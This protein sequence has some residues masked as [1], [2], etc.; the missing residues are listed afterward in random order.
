MEES[1]RITLETLRQSLQAVEPAALLV[2]PRIL[3]RVIRHDRRLPGLGVLVPHRKSYTIERERLL[4]FVDRSE[5][6]LPPSADLPRTVILLSKPAEDEELVLGDGPELLHQ[7]WRQLFHA[8]VHVELEQH[9][10]H[11]ES[12]TLLAMQRRE[13]IGDA[14]FA[15]IRAVLLKDDFLFPEPSDLEVY[16]EFAAVYLELRYFAEQELPLYF[17]AIRDWGEIDRIVSQDIDHAPLFVGARLPG[18]P[19]P[20]WRAGEQFHGSMEGAPAPLTEPTRAS[21]S[22]FRVFQAR[23][24]RA[25]A[26]GNGIKA[27]IWQMR[28]ARVGTK[29]GAKEARAA[30]HLELNRFTE[31][32]RLA[33]ES[34]PEEAQEWRAALEPLLTPAAQGYWSNEARLLYDLQKVCVERERGVFKLDLIEWLRTLGRRPMRRPLPLLREALT[35]RHL[36]TAQRRVDASR[37]TVGDRERLS[38]LLTAAVSSAEHRVRERIRPLV[39]EVFDDVGLTPQNTP[40]RVARRKLIEELL[41]RIVDHGYLSMG[42]LRDALSKNDLKLP[43]VASPME[44]VVGDRLLQ[45]DRKLDTVLD[46][47]YRRGAVYLR[48]PQT[49]SSLAFGTN[50]GRFITQYVAVPFGGAYLTLEFLS[51]VVE[52]ISGHGHAHGHGPV[53]TSAG[54]DEITE[55][56]AEIAAGH[57][58][59]WLY[60]TCVLALGVW[61]LL[62]IHNPGF[63]AW[64]VAALLRGW[65]LL[66]DLLVDLPARLIRS[67]L[68]QRIINSQVYAAVHSYVLRPAFTTFLVWLP[69]LALGRPWSARLALEIFLVA[70]LFLNSPI[71]RYAVELATDLLVRAWHELRMRIFAAVFQWIMDLSHAVM[72]AL[73]RVVYTVDEWLRFRTGDSRVA[74]AFKLLGGVV[75]FFVAYVVVFAFTLLIEPQVNPIKHFPVVTVSHKLILPSGPMF[76]REL[77]PYIGRAE[78]NT[79]VWTTIWLIPGVFGFLVWELKENWRLYAANRPRTLRGVSIGHH[80]ETMARLLRP[81]FHSGT[82]PKAFATLRR[83]A[84]KAEK[85]GDWKAISRKRSVVKHVEE[86]VCRFVE[87]ELVEL[88]DEVGFMAPGRLSVGEVRTATNRI[89]VELKRSDQH[90]PSAWLTW[91][92]MAGRLQGQV[93]RAGWLDALDAWERDLFSAALA[94][95]F[96]RA[97]VDQTSGPLTVTPSRIGWEEWV[98]FWSPAETAP[99]GASKA[100]RQA[101]P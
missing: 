92:D 55:I 81:G 20:E 65:R 40:E 8:C 46:G 53:E 77:T 5:L 49:L 64:N 15:E 91:E 28:A 33:L 30:A 2:E 90:G 80:G 70:A 94:G 68:V 83:A 22:Q 98:D 23:A 48:W 96:Q 54:G 100:V 44:V 85:N 87:R 62:L 37:M 71:G 76:V 35:T 63:R 16:V 25:S 57:E 43:D 58:P 9:I 78:A 74:Q 14:E 21:P 13:E 99:A 101:V 34:A 24:A 38:S 93:S 6:E 11:Q 36:R 89:E 86:A 79:L 29:K 95:L 60:Y 42:D 88:L 82:L 32:L 72:V 27:A 39:T 10:S 3:R 51:H 18:A 1:P 12:P 50:V 56:A 61:L 26:V 97:G 66:R 45:A 67:R 19:T 84:R 4:A 17:P 69:F 41:D 75:W 52:S 73:D 47:V 59:P 7:Y 31:R